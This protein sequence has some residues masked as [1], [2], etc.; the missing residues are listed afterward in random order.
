MNAHSI[1]QRQL[2]TTRQAMQKQVSSQTPGGSYENLPPGAPIAHNHT[3]APKAVAKPQGGTLTFRHRVSGSKLIAEYLKLI[4]TRCNHRAEMLLAQHAYK[5]FCNAYDGCADWNEAACALPYLELYEHVSPGFAFA[6][7]GWACEN[8]EEE[9]SEYECRDAIKGMLGELL[10][11]RYSGS[12]S[13]CALEDASK[14]TESL[15][16]ATA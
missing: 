7:M 10:R 1:T 12:M 8:A 15:V 6:W 2:S 14:R 5:S 9:L 16:F 11:L 13:A 4:D 3:S